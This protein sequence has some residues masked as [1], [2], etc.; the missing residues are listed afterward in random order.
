MLENEETTF[1]VHGGMLRCVGERTIKTEE[2]GHPEQKGEGPE[3]WCASTIPVHGQLSQDM[4]GFEAIL[5][6]ETKTKRSGEQERVALARRGAAEV[7]NSQS[8]WDFW[9]Q[10][11][12][13]SLTYAVIIIA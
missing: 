7:G 8:Q 5:G 6:S 1:C 13:S 4:G 10:G 2:S 3:W 9:G 11:D 12:V